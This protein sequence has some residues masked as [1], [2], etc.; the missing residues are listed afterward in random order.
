MEA[1]NM[2]NVLFDP[3]LPE[4][5]RPTGWRVCKTLQIGRQFDTEFR[6][7]TEH[8]DCTTKEEAEALK[9]TIRTRFGDKVT[10]CV[11]PTFG[12][13]NVNEHQL[14]LAEGWPLQMAPSRIAAHKPRR[15]KRT[16]QPS[17]AEAD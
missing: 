13:H 7:I 17:R 11:V 3:K 1:S 8:L 12:T 6:P 5:D 2:S 16:R 9:D 4:C 10:V 15:A 14:D